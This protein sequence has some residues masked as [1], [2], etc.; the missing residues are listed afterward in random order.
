MHHDTPVVLEAF[1]DT[2][3]DVVKLV[4]ALE[5]CMVKREEARE[6]NEYGKA[7]QENGAPALV[8]VIDRGLSADG[9]WI[10]PHN[11]GSPNAP[12]QMEIGDIKS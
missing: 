2:A 10:L 6:R 4:R 7:V 12:T 5:R 9:C 1:A 3:L 8:S 11:R